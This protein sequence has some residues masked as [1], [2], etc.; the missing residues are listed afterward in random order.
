[1]WG[2]VIIAGLSLEQTPKKFK[3]FLVLGFSLFIGSVMIPLSFFF[4]LN[5]NKNWH[6]VKTN[7]DLPLR[8]SSPY[9]ELRGS[10]SCIGHLQL[11]ANSEMLEHSMHSHTPQQ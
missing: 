6:G 9:L 7:P 8:Q 10:S 3:P 11:L 2:G 1:M 4:F 5:L